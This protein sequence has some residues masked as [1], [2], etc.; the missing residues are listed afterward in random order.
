M[1]KTIILVLKPSSR[2]VFERPF[3]TAS[4]VRRFEV[5]NGLF[6]LENSL[7]FAEISAY[8]EIKLFSLL[9]KSKGIIINKFHQQPK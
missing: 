4:S 3:K 9:Y 1:N 7:T 6:D 5:C 2:V 8:S